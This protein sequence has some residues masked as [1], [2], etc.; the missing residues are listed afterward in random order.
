MCSL[1]SNDSV[2]EYPRTF[3]EIRVDVALYGE[4]TVRNEVYCPRQRMLALFSNL[5]AITIFKIW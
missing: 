2:N 5:L 1:L 4:I 3:L